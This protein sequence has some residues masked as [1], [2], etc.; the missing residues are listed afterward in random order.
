MTLEDPG[1][2][3]LAPSVDDRAETCPNCGASLLPTFH[4]SPDLTIRTLLAVCD[5]LVVKALERLGNL[6]VRADKGRYNQIRD[7]LYYTAHTK[8][9]ADDEFVTRALKNAWDVVPLLLDTHGSQEFDA[10]RAVAVLDEYVHDLVVSGSAHDF[11]TL[12]YRLR[13]GLG[14]PVLHIG[15][16]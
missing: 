15:H 5:V 4:G 11:N 14:L 3:L 12:A 8:W 2:A 13:T 10:A 1:S 7:D 16:S 6:I 9:P